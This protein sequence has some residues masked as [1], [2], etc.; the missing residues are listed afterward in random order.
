MHSIRRPVLCL[1]SLILW[2]LFR[3]IVS[4]WKSIIVALSVPKLSLQIHCIIPN[5]PL[6]CCFPFFCKAFIFHRS[7]FTDL[8]LDEWRKRIFWFFRH[9][10]SVNVHYIVILYVDIKGISLSN[11]RPWVEHE[12]LEIFLSKSNIAHCCKW[13]QNDYQEYID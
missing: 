7:Y 11:T 13:T 1:I 3:V 4:Y 9:F 8:V 2:E 10:V 5:T 6:F 12:L